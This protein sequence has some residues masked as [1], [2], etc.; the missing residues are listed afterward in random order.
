MKKLIVCETPF[1]IIIALYIKQLYTNSD[2]QVDIIIGD[3][4]NGYENIADRIRN[5]NLFSNVYTANI[6]IFF[7][8]DKFKKISS[9]LSVLN[10]KKIVRN[11]FGSNIIQYDEMYCW[12]YDPFTISI[13]SYFSIYKKAIKMFI[14]EEG[15]ISYFPFDEV[16]NKQVATR[17]IEFRNKLFGIKDVTRQNIEAL[18]LFEPDLLLYDPLCPIYKM[19]RSIGMTSQFRKNVNDIFNA[20]EAALKYDKKYIIFEENHPEYDDEPIFDRIIEK[21]GKE[22]VIIKLHPL[23]KED[24]FFKKGIKTLGNDG[25]PW[26]AICYAGEFADKVLIAIGSG[27]ITSYRMLFGN[28]MNAFL[29]YKFVDSNLKQFDKKFSRF[30]DSLEAKD[31]NGGIYMPETEKEFFEK[32]EKLTKG[33]EKNENS[34]VCTN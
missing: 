20:R 1:Q 16:V 19:D 25:V 14:F 29:L 32:L 13:R 26:E 3:T 31:M 28:H 24:R 10:L 21:V 7:D 6:K 4:F 5:L 8:R 18:L 22:N 27:S 30:W 34:S 17:V 2:D 23:R 33:S 15:Y 11:T 9:I 12:N